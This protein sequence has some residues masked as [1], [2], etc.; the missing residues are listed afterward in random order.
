MKLRVHG[1]K[2]LVTS[3]FLGQFENMGGEIIKIVIFLMGGWC[4]IH[5]TRLE[6]WL[7]MRPW[8]GW[9]HPKKVEGQE[10]M[11]MLFI[12]FLL[13]FI[14][15]RKE[16]LSLK[17]NQ[18]K[19]KKLQQGGSWSKLPSWIKLNEDLNIFFFFCRRDENVVITIW[20]QMRTISCKFLMGH[21][22]HWW[23][24]CSLCGCDSFGRK[25]ISR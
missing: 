22:P 6:K 23:N 12:Y 14:F 13:I 19:K 5:E 9:T 24:I 18:K 1:S 8:D 17:E 7:K 25:R 3:A 4:C 15:G 21:G 16:K 20:F 10:E 2:K 11:D